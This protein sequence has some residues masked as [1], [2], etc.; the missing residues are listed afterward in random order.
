MMTAE[1]ETSQ[2]MDRDDKM[3]ESKENQVEVLQSVRV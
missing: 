3:A 1:N 2:T